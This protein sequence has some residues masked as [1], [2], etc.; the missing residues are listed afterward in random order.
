MNISDIEKYLEEF[1]GNTYKK[2]KNDCDKNDDKMLR[3]FLKIRSPLGDYNPYSLYCMK[4]LNIIDKEFLKYN[5]FDQD[6]GFSSVKTWH[7]DGNDFISINEIYSVINELEVI[8]NNI[9]V[10]KQLCSR[11]RVLSILNLWRDCLDCDIGFKDGITQKYLDECKLYFKGSKN[12]M[13]YSRLLMKSLIEAKYYE[14]PDFLPLNEIEYRNFL[15]STFV[16]AMLEPHNFIDGSE[17]DNINIVRGII[18][19]GNIMEF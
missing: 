16:Y 2:F 10:I 15:D 13:R 12:Y 14:T 19:D 3:D 11:V 17:F 9:K 6:E 5:F 4:V 8:P 7:K 1:T 18:I